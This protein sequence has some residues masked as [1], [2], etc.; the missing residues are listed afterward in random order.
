MKNKCM[1]LFFRAFFLLFIN[2]EGV[3]LCLIV[4]RKRGNADIKRCIVCHFKGAIVGIQTQMV[5]CAK[6]HSSIYIKNYT[7]KK[8]EQKNEK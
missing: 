3:T 7:Q 5:V 6:L 8:E 4:W 1:K 2:H